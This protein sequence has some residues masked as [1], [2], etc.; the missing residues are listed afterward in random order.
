MYPNLQ[1]NPMLNPQQNTPQYPHNAGTTSVET[2]TS[3]IEN[4]FKKWFSSG[5]TDSE[6]QANA[7]T[8]QMQQRAMEY[9]SSEAT[10]QMEFQA[11]QAQEARSWQEQMYDKYYSPASQVQQYKDAGLNPA[12]LYGRGAS[13]P[14]MP[15]PTT[16][17]GGASG[18]VSGGSSVT[19]SY[20]NMFDSLYALAQLSSQLRVS[21]S[22]ADKYTSEAVGQNIQNQFSPRV[23]EQ[24]LD[25]GVVEIANL[26]AG[27][28]Q[29]LANTGLIREQKL[30]ESTR[31]ALF[32]AQ[33]VLADTQQTSLSLDN[34]Q[35]RWENRY[36]RDFGFRPD[37][38]LLKNMFHMLTK[39]IG[40]YFGT[41]FGNEYPGAQW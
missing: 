19:P 35:K 12:L 16:P 17:S 31:R 20:H 37:D 14:S 24:N 27:V 40:K 3:W 11:K 21:N 36:I 41:P 10:R 26:K 38:N 1:L 29:I 6:L 8:Q 5:L 25:K 30:T 22:L 23:L 28:D 33:K 39:I 18:Q 4:L 34:F 9:N 32:S 15:S 2:G 13:T 7:F